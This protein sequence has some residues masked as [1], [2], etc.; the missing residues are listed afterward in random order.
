MKT[1]KKIN[2]FIVDNSLFY[3]NLYEQSLR[4]LGHTNIST[5]MS[6]AECIAALAEKPNVIFLDSNLNNAQSSEVL[7]RIKLFNPGIFVIMLID[8]AGIR[9]NINTSNF[10]ISDYIIKGQDEIA[11]ANSIILKINKIINAPSIKKMMNVFML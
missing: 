1:E 8:P 4:D 6:G 7:R 5:F 9:T 2:I 3:L 11:K 10:G